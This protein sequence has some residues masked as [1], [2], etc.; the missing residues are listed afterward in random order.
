MEE[1]ECRKLF[2]KKKKALTVAVYIFPPSFEN[3]SNGKIPKN[4]NSASF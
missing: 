1:Q 4:I 2:F 3:G